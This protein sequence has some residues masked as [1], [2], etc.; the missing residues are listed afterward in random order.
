MEI[1]DTFHKVATMT[2]SCT[3]LVPEAFLS[4]EVHAVGNDSLTG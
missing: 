2:D 1:L 3:H 4:G